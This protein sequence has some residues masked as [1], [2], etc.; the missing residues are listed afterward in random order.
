VVII[1]VCT[2]LFF[3]GKLRN[4]ISREKKGRK[5]G[6]TQI[7]MIVICTGFSCVL[8]VGKDFHIQVF[9]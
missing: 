3:L 6:V 2:V 7:K 5:R 4:E 8:F 1:L 9:F